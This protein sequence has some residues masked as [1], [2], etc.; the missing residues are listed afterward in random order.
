MNERVDL[1]MWDLMK[2]HA[3]VVAS[4]R[5]LNQCSEISKEDCKEL[6]QAKAD[7]VALWNAL[8]DWRPLSNLD[9]QAKL[10]YFVEFLRTTKTS[11]DA[12]TTERV[13]NAIEHLR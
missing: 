12:E 4:V 11:L 7:S 3:N 5:S 8:V 6:A 10:I 13:L 1:E 2:R 9:A